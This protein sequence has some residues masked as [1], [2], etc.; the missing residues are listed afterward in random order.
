MKSILS[1]RETFRRWLQL[2][3][4][5]SNH[6]SFFSSSFV[7]RWRTVDC[8][9][10][11]IR[12]RNKMIHFCMI[13]AM[14]HMLRPNEKQLFALTHRLKNICSSFSC[15][16]LIVF[17][18]IATCKNNK[19]NHF[20]SFVCNFWWLR[21]ACLAL[22]SLLRCSHAVQKV[23]HSRRVAYRK[24]NGRQRRSDHRAIPYEAKTV[25]LSLLDAVMWRII[26]RDRNCKSLNAQ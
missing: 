12:I 17:E 8:C 13:N 5:R 15:V 20:N 22:K 6:S 23:E 10:L 3:M 18:K 7:F 19:I 16:W 24:E 25:A 21:L 26:E 14:L 2:K 11:M 4:I 1:E 9:R